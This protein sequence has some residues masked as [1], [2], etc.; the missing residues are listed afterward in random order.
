MIHWNS[1]QVLGLASSDHGSLMWTSSR[2]DR[3]EASQSVAEQGATWGPA[4]PGPLLDGLET[5]ARHGHKSWVRR[6]RPSLLSETAATN[7]TLFSVPG[8]PYP[9]RARHRDRH[10]RPGPGLRGHDTPHT[11]RPLAEHHCQS[12]FS[13]TLLGC[14]S[15]QEA[16]G[17]ARTHR[18]NSDPSQRCGKQIETDQCIKTCP[19]ATNCRREHGNLPVNLIHQPPRK[20]AAAEHQSITNQHKNPLFSAKIIAK[21]RQ[22]IPLQKPSSPG[23]GFFHGLGVQYLNCVCVGRC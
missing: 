13:F 5:E 20:L 22:E 19:H 17:V 9:R 21:Y 14:R 7:G 1:W 12:G 4:G 10:R 11:C 3:S 2:G 18:L 6:G 8:R 16:S 23:L 15:A